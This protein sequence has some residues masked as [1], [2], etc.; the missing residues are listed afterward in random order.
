MQADLGAR[1]IVVNIRQVELGTFLT[2]ARAPNK[3]FDV[4]VAGVPGDVALAFLSAM[5]EI[6][7]GGR[8]AGLHR[9]PLAAARFALCVDARRAHRRGAR[10]G[11]GAVQR[12]LADAVARRV[13]LSLARLAGALG[14]TAQRRDGSSRR[15]GDAVA[16]GA[17][18]VA[19]SLLL[20]ERG[21]R[22]A[23]GR[24]GGPAATARGVARGRSRTA[25]RRAT[26]TS[27]TSKALLSREGGRCARDGTLLE[28]DP[29]KPHEHRCPRL[30][31]GLSRRA[32]RSL[33][34]LLVSALARRARGAR[35]RAVST[36]RRRSIRR[37]RDVDSRRIRRAILDVSERRQRA[38]A[39]ASVL[40]HVPR[41]DLAAPD[42][43][44]DRSARRDASGAHRRACA[45]RSSSRA[46][47]SSPS[48]TRARRIDRCGM[49]S[50]CLAAS[51]LLGDDAGAENAVFGPSGIVA[52]LGGGL[53]ADGTWYEGENY[54]L[55][56]HR[57]LWYGVT[58]AETAGLELPTP[59]VDRFQ[60]GFATPF[61]TA[62]PDFTFP[63][64]RD[65]QYAISLRQWRIAEHCELGFARRADPELAAALEPPVSRRH[66][67]PRHG[68]A[69][70]VG[71]RRAQRAGVVAHA[72]RPELARAAVRP[73]TLP[74]LEAGGP[75]SAL[76]DAQGI[77]VFRRN[78]GR[79]Y[80]ALDYGHSGGGHG[81]PDRLNLLLA[82]GDTRWLDDLGTGSYVD[83]SLHWYRSTLAHNAPLVD[84]V[85]QARVNGTLDAY[86][87][88]GAAGW[89]VAS[90]DG[91]APPTR[92]DAHGRRDVVVRDRRA[93]VD[94]RRRRHRRPADP[95]RHRAARRA[96][97]RARAAQRE[98]GTGGRLSIP[99]R[100]DAAVGRRAGRRSRRR[101]DANRRA[102]CRVWARSD[103]DTDWWRAI[104]ARAARRR[105][106]RVSHSSR[107]CASGPS[108]FRHGVVGATSSTSSSATTIRVTLADGTTHVHRRADDGWQIELHAGGARSS[109]DLRRV[110][111]AHGGDPAGRR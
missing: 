46:A 8:G 52:H 4:L 7:T 98:P 74:P 47:R 71:R 25:A 51:R 61:A 56:A 99:P 1:G 87:E 86:D 2:Q 72:R 75:R 73:P 103:Q 64:R 91:I 17:R 42:L 31:R 68:A 109:I 3:Q 26:S 83:P 82:D 80:V 96:R 34:D 100:H 57:G 107:A 21:A 48:T 30:R 29:F 106:S 76:L 54:H 49:T 27:R 70:I 108:S 22:R 81:H 36:R 93:D 24:R 33:L 94:G 40:Q 60:R 35:G 50:R 79:T 84:G 13:D 20:S 9:I 19:M 12:L 90:S 55:F 14:A 39:D 110:R 66:S 18:A 28:F 89:I 85:S 58:M 16:L 41:V 95:R 97:D 38:R 102:H 5:F 63:S 32:A 69:H 10:R 6:A 65:S 44:R 92:L 11:V 77:A 53:L 15:D 43:R 101:G 37:A 104:V 59:L 88:R 23:T 67:A 62:L 45:T 105:R 78:E 111:R